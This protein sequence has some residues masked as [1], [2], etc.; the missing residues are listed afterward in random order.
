MLII[1]ASAIVP[2]TSV[3]SII[4]AVTV[5]MLAIVAI[6]KEYDV[7][8]ILL[9]TAFVLGCLAG[10]IR[11][12]T[13]KFFTTLSDEKFIVPICSAMGFA[14]VLKQTQCDQNLVRLLLKPLQRFRLLLYPGVVLVGFL[15]NI[16]VISQTSTA[17]CLGAVVIPILRTAGYAPSAIGA[18][19][20]VGS[21]LGG[22]LLNPGAPELNTI[23]HSQNCSAQ[24]VVPA[25]SRL[26]FVH[27]AITL[28]LFWGIQLWRR[29]G[30]REVLPLP[31][32]Q[33]D[34]P[35]RYFKAL[36]PI[37]PLLVLFVTGPPLSLL[38]FPD[39]WVAE[40]NQTQAVATRL[41]G[42]AMLAGV[43]TAALASPTQALTLPVT[44]FQGAGYA[45]AHI[46]SIIVAASC[47]GA[48]IQ[49]IGLEYWLQILI[50]DFP[51]L[52]VPLA[53]SIPLIFGWVSGS[54]MAATQSLYSLFVPPAEAAGLDRLELGALV[55]IAAAAG[56]T[57]SPVAAVAIMSATLTNTNPFQ[58]VRRVFVPLIASWILVVCLI[59]L[60]I[61]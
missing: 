51:S 7:R 22:E 43:V 8:L 33:Q 31:A 55:S 44:F 56:R 2:S 12:I 41:I 57:M 15:V 16:P 10:D 17:V 61:L 37:V 34:Q 59:L 35:I 52:L 13:R 6:A 58:L 38:Q 28:V 53:A 23:A 50:H 39:D 47:F 18:A 46:I 9:L 36:V 11:P 60:K 14:Y 32:L 26:I 25:V 19:I 30:P 24:E 42:V 20:L 27:L 45:F 4:L 54:G 49:L 3:L 5:F 29:Q 1:L 40:A 21:S 48:A